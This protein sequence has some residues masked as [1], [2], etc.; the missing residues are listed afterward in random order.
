MS[1][2][3]PPEDVERIQGLSLDEFAE[4]SAAIAEGDRPASQVLEQ[5]G[6]TDAK[7]AN[8]SLAWMRRMAEDVQLHRERARLPIQYADTFGR[9]QNARKAV[10]A[11]SVEDWAR[12]TVEVMQ[13]GSPG[14]ALIARGLSQADYL[15]LA[16]HFAAVLSQDSLA[17][18][19]FETTFAALQPTEVQG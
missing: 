8:V 2:N 4:I 5:R 3:A 1:T 16:R 18:R 15:R 19:R 17:A 12:L 9:A 13:H 6:L 10:V 7:W 11:M 14:P